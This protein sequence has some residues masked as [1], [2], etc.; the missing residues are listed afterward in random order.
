L[1]D[2]ILVDARLQDFGPARAA[3]R[4]FARRDAVDAPSA[5]GFALG[6]RNRLGPGDGKDC[7]TVIR[8]GND[9]SQPRVGQTGV[10]RC[11]ARC[12]RRTARGAE[13][14][15]GERHPQEVVEVRSR[16]WLRSGGSGIGSHRN[17]GHDGIGGDSAVKLDN[18]EARE[19]QASGNQQVNRQTIDHGFAMTSLAQNP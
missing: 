13:Q 18:D 16:L 1:S 7:Q 12:L 17:L 11:V 2:G 8:L 3:H 19:Q 6:Q 9:S 10:G 5:Y 15:A 14:R 4:Y